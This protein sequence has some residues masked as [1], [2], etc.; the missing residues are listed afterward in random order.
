MK[1]IGIIVIVGWILRLVVGA[2]LLLVILGGLV[3]ATNNTEP[4]SPDKAQYAIQTYS[5][6]GMRIPSRIYFTNEVVY[7]GNIPTVKDYWKYD[8]EKYQHVKSEKE[9][10]GIVTIVRRT[11]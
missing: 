3:F 11:Q 2:F 1:N 5:D 6:D 8:G 4:P 7:N 10:T 9:L